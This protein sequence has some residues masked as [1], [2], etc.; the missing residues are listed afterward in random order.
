MHLKTIPNGQYTPMSPCVWFICANVVT[1]RKSN[2]KHNQI[3]SI[4][5]SH[6]GLENISTLKKLL[7]ISTL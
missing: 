1:D 5:T 2:V 4:N 7:S 3:S 6:N